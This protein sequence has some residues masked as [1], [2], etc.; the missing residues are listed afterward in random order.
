MQQLCIYPKP[1]NTNFLRWK[2]MQTVV[3]AV[4]EVGGTI[5]GGYVRDRII[6]DHYATEFYSK[7]QYTSLEKY[8]DENYM[9]ELNLRTLIPSDIDCCMITSN[10][11]KLKD[12]LACNMLHVVD[13]GTMCASHYF[14]CLP[15]NVKHTKLKIT[16]AVN[17]LLLSLI[18][19]LT[20]EVKLDIVHSDGIIEPPINVVDFECNGIILTPDNE[21]KIARV[22]LPQSPKD[23]IDMMNRIM[24]DIIDR[25]TYIVFEDSCR[26]RIMRMLGKGWTI[27]SPCITTFKLKDSSDEIEETCIICLDTFKIND[28]YAKFRCCKGSRM[29]M[30][31][32]AK[33]LKTECESCP[34]CRTELVIQKADL[35][36]VG[37]REKSNAI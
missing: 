3:S 9:P 18:D 7:A 12:V 36:I 23:K 8:A 27:S 22:M 15:N 1:P 35:R 14:K 28:Y 34:T 5:F 26:H 2:L 11:S 19:T 25:Q 29:H 17:P 20:Y 32:A 13:T 10:I 30:G 37:A 16:F 33:L 4:Q 6:H 31:C 24:K 21:Y